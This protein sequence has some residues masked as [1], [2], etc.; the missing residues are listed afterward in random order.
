VRRNKG[1]SGRTSSSA[2]SGRSNTNN[3]SLVAK[4]V[5]N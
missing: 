3:E 2:K 4:T 1:H 5:T